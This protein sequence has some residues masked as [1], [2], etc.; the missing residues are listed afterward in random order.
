M[1]GPLPMPE[2][3]RQVG[4]SQSGKVTSNLGSRDGILYQT[5]SRLPI[6]NQVFLGSWMVDIYQEGCSQRS[7]PQKRHMAH[8]RQRCHCTPRKLSSWDQGGDKM[9]RQ[10]EC[11]RQAPGCLSCLDL[12][13]AQNA[14][15]TKFVP[16][17]SSQEPEPEWLRPGK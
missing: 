8:L 12:G 15:P 16:L 7:A 11:T 17:R 1:D 14:D 4:N 10:G 6:A 13:R 3:E 5:V 2:A 9:H